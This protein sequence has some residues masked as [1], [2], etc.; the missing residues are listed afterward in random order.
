[1]FNDPTMTG[2]PASAPS[3]FPHARVASRPAERP[4]LGTALSSADRPGNGPALVARPEAMAPCALSARTTAALRVR[5]GLATRRPGAART[6][7]CRA[8]GLC[9]L[10]CCCG[11][12]AFHGSAISPYGLG[13]LGAVGEN[14]VRLVRHVV[15][16]RRRRS[17]KALRKETGDCHPKIGDVGLIGAWAKVLGNIQA[18][19]CSRIALWLGRAEGRA[20]LHD[21][22]GRVG[23]DHR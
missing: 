12:Y 9:H 22:G 11:G 23:E 15:E 14:N 16:W 7:F 17:M 4:P 5:C 8:C 21:P 2:H 3:P 13:Q 19:N 1:M 10:V 18:G 6:P 20:I